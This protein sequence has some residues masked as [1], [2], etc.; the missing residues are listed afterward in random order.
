MS[1]RIEN[2]NYSHSFI[3]LDFRLYMCDASRET[4]DESK[5]KVVRNDRPMCIL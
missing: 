5:A 3:L 2:K 4:G 1:L